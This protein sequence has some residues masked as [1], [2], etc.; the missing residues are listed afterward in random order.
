MLSSE[1]PA[2]ARRRAVRFARL[3]VVA[4]TVLIATATCTGY[5]IGQRLA[6]GA[7]NDAAAHRLEIFIAS[8]F[9]PVDRFEYLPELM[10]EHPAVL[11]ALRNPND[12]RSQ[13]ALNRILH[14]SGTKAGAA[15][16]YVMNRDGVT[17]AASNWETPDSFL[18]KDFSYRPYFQQ[19]RQGKTGRFYGVGSVTGIPGYFLGSAVRDA[20][21]VIGVVAVKVDL[22][23]L[24]QSWLADSGQIAVTD[25]SGIIFLST[26]R[27][28]KYRATRTLSAG[29]LHRLRETRQYATMLKAPISFSPDPLW[30]DGRV[31][32]ADGIETGDTQRYF[33]LNHSLPQ[34]DWTITSYSSMERA[35]QTALVAAFI[36]AGGMAFV[37]L[38]AMYVRLV[39]RRSKEKEAARQAAELAHMELEAKHR[40]L[41]ALSQHLQTMAISDPLTG[42]NNRRYFT[43]IAEKM[44]SAA[45]RHDRRISVLMLDIDFFKRINDTFGHPVGDETLKAVAAACRSVLRQPDFLVRFGG[46]EFVAI[47]P[48]TDAAEAMVA[49]E[50]A[51][52]EVQALQLKSGQR[53]LTL[54]ISIGVAEYQRG[55]TSLDQALARADTA[56][57]QAKRGGR[58]RCVIHDAQMDSAELAAPGLAH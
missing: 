31:V 9:S 18:G 51:R 1:K 48:D 12:P 23:R 44:V 58:N 52:S 57:Y 16:V 47:L 24:D 45:Q 43:E 3:V 27:D 4:C 25:D 32:R 26:N 5:V 7:L 14:D 8:F 34:A 35:E 55:E 30:F 49:A 33:M 10:A 50:R 36:A 46:E 39:K 13:S 38:L 54:T 17:I 15:A 19:A 21:D 40:E 20:G 11:E 22:D 41:E 37:L 53:T 29:V 6:I 56:L 2:K 42:C 28:W